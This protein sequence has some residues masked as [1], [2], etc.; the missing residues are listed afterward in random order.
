[1]QLC[2]YRNDDDIMT[3]QMKALHELDNVCA[4]L[5]GMEVR[6]LMK[7]MLGSLLQNFKD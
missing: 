3:P 2:S 4:S 7:V 1:M 5:T 6:N